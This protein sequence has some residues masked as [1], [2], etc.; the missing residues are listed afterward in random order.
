MQT[1]AYTR[2]RSGEVQA[3]IRD[4]AVKLPWILIENAK[5]L[6]KCSF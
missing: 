3:N 4:N 6:R 5:K 2:I 1:F